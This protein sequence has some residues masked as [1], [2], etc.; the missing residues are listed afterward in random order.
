[1][2]RAG[3]FAGRGEVRLHDVRIALVERDLRRGLDPGHDDAAELRRVLVAVLVHVSLQTLDHR[4]RDVVAGDQR[5]GADAHEIRAAHDEL[6]RVPPVA[7][8]AGHHDLPLHAVDLANF[9]CVALRERLEPRSAVAGHADLVLQV[10]DGLARVLEVDRR[11]AEPVR[12]AADRVRAGLVERLRDARDLPALGR[13]LHKQRDVN[14]PLDRAHDLRDRVPALAEARA[15]LFRGRAAPAGGQLDV[16]GHVRAAHV[17]LDDVRA[18]LLEPLRHVHPALRAL[19][20]GIGDV[21]HQL[22]VGQDLLRLLDE[23]QTL[24]E[25]QALLG[26]ERERVA[27]PEHAVARLAVDVGRGVDRQLYAGRGPAALLDALQ[28]AHG[29]RR[30]AGRDVERVFKRHAADRHGNEYL[31]HG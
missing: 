6:D 23:L 21:G 28:L 20:A 7:H 19:V 10:V 3:V 29:F 9:I 18:D 16:V 22:E 30:R 15:G 2:V 27:V 13:Q 17:Q 11:Y 31:L 26:R 5:L 24:G 1:M 8:A 14:L 4:P 25:G 12:G